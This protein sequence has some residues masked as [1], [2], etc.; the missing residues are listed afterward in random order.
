VSLRTGFMPLV[1]SG[2]PP[3]CAAWGRYRRSRGWG[4]HA[5]NLA[6]GGPPSP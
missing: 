4:R 1:Q 6:S 5:H 3:L 2:P